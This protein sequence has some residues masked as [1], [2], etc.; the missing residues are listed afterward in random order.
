M[1]KQFINNDRASLVLMVLASFCISALVLA[2]ASAVYAQTDT[3]TPTATSTPFP[4][5]T[6]GPTMTPAPTIVATM[7]TDEIVGSITT[8]SWWDDIIGNVKT[9][10]Q[11]LIDRVTQIRD[12]ITSIQTSINLRLSIFG[13]QIRGHSP[14][15]FFRGAM[16]LF[17]DFE[18]MA[19]LAG[20]FAIAIVAIVVITTIRFIVA[21][22]GVVE[23]LMSIIKTIP[24]FVVAFMLALS[25]TGASIVYAQTATPTATI[26]P[27]ATATFTPTVTRTPTSTTT[28]TPTATPTPFAILHDPSFIVPDGN[29]WTT[30]SRDV[31][32]NYSRYTIPSGEAIS[33]TVT[34]LTGTHTYSVTVRAMAA[35]TGTMSVYA[36]G[37]L[38]QTFT[39]SQSHFMRSF[40]VTSSVT[41]PS[42]VMAR[43][44]SG[45]P[46]VVDQVAL[47]RTD[48]SFGSM[49]TGGGEGVPYVNPK[50]LEIGDY[51]GFWQPFDLMPM[52]GK[53][54]FQVNWSTYMAP[55]GQIAATLLYIATP[56]IITYWFSARV[57]IMC[58]LWLIGFVMQKIGKPI[59]PTDS[60]NIIV[61]IGSSIMRGEGAE[62]YVRRHSA[63][64]SLG[65]KSG[66]W[67]G[68]K[69]GRRS[70][71]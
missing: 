57:I 12:T 37:T 15:M 39:V 42:A 54:Y 19:I 14:F 5:A 55:I 9:E 66:V 52:F 13:M 33:Q 25:L 30:S 20:W 32:W 36:G 4:T 6:T 47:E 69:R 62:G 65:P 41:F 56:T 43:T 22:W 18:W 44:A 49:S 71:W 67:G 53:E 64:P 27:T 1:D 60:G 50:P 68:R 38:L 58:V 24:F 34:Y 2:S 61:G 59:P 45:G 28:S 16:I 70:R 40:V 26:T 46:V 8:Q 11:K 63:F 23:R 3:P 31:T 21:F 17:S 35:T 51:Q 48:G 10:I 29:Y 7:T